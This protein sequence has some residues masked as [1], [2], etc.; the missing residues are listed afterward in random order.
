MQFIVRKPLRL[1]LCMYTNQS[2][3]KESKCVT[4]CKCGLATPRLCLLVDRPHLHGLYM[5]R[6]CH[7]RSA[8]LKFIITEWYIRY[9][10]GG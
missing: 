9:Q 3:G 6:L 7:A 10:A 8:I 2:V 4:P 1:L 5:Y